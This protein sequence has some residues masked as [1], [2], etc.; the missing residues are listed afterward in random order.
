MIRS[1]TVPLV[2][3]VLS[4]CPL[5]RAAAKQEPAEYKQGDTA[6]EGLFVYNE[7][8]AAKKPAVIVVHDW[9]GFGFNNFQQDRCAE[10][11]A[12][13]Y[14]AFACDIYGKG[15]R[16]KDKSEAPQ[17]A[18]KF[19]SDRALLRARVIAAFEAVKNHP[20]VD[21]SKIGAIG[22]CFGGTTVLELAR[23]GTPV[24]G[25]VSFHGGLNTPT[26][27]DAKNIKAKVLALHGAD[28]PFVPPEEVLAFEKEMREAKVDWQL[29]SYGGSVHSF[30]NPAAGTDNS[31]GAAYNEAANRRSW[32]AM[33]N[34]FEE[35]F[36]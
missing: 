8:G 27:G 32:L 5:A 17:Y 36:K 3:M 16:P 24:A 2:L 22:Y 31:K 15:S 13:G 30:T 6:L 9:M 33:K 23:S 12:L 28:D 26:P 34:F 14:V 11:A 10:L 20:R 1:L 25:V 35:T 19:K 4:L 18:G 7:D 29:V 21:A